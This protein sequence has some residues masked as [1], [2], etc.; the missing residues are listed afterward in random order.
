V[1]DSSSQILEGY[2]AIDAIAENLKC[3]PRTIYRLM[4]EPDG[5]PFVK[6]GGRNY[7]HIE[8]VR[9]WVF[10]HRQQRNPRRKNKRA[11]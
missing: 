5:L 7:F 6:I 3:T 10:A 9:A 1:K 11:A 4:N 8:T 2:L